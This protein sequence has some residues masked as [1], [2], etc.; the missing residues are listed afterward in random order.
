MKTTVRKPLIVKIKKLRLR[1]LD[2]LLSVNSNQRTEKKRR[3]RRRRRNVEQP[4]SQSEKRLDRAAVGKL[5]PVKSF[6]NL[7]GNETE[8]DVLRKIQNQ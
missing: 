6:K 1:N 7:V 8:K 5:P 3:R 4:V 2:N